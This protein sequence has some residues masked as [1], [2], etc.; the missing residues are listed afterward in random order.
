MKAVLDR[1]P[2]HFDKNVLVLKEL[3]SGVQPATIEFNQAAFWVRI[4]ELP[5]TAR[6]QRIITLIAGRIGTL[7]EIDSR[8]LEGFGR[9]I[10]AKIRIDI[11]RPLR[12]GIH[13]E[14]QA[15][16]KMWVEFKYERLPSFCYICGMLGHMRKECD[17]G[18][19]MEGLEALPETKLPFGEWMRASPS[20]NATIITE[21]NQRSTEQSSLR[22]RLF[23]KFKQSL[24]A[25]EGA[26]TR[27]IWKRLAIHK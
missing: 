9:S 8:S 17:L 19:G 20:K 11:R 2:C 21:E 7:L 5:M 14:I 13:M 22:R 3:G 6:N 1:E 15:N 24:D 10:R 4:Y 26:L 27:K 16:K 18:S 12:S 23:E 25:E